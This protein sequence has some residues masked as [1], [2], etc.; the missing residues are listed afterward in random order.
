MNAST[1]SQR[2]PQ[3]LVGLRGPSRTPTHL[4][5]AGTGSARPVR[6]FHTLRALN[7]CAIP[8]PKLRAALH[9]LP[10]LFRARSPG[11]RAVPPVAR[12]VRRHF[13]SWTLIALRHSLRPA[14][15]FA[16]SGSLHYRVPRPGFGYPLRDMT[17]GPPDASSASERPWASPFK[18]FP[19][20]RSV[21]LSEPL[22]SCRYLAATAPPR[23][24][25]SCGVGR[26][27]GLVPVTS[28][29]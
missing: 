29:C 28:P 4:P 15:S 7:K 22:P 3:A 26:L 24:A 23:R 14:A 10:L 8:Q 12:Q 5:R 25:A 19:S 1:A 11:P 13:L 9:G 20:P 21:P 6:R 18:G 17:T 27:Q 16:G 2:L